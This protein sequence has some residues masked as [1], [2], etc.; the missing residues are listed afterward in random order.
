M[1]FKC[2]VGSLEQIT[3]M[4]SCSFP[5]VLSLDCFALRPKMFFNNC[6]CRENNVTATIDE[7][8]IQATCIYLHLI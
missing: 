6:S 3:R 4:V 8:W 1:H 2:P 5:V 7:L